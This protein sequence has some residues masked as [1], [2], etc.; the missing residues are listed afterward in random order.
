MHLL[1]LKALADVLADIK[2]LANVFAYNK[3]LDNVLSDTER[4]R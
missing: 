4:G 3:T 2:V 1:I